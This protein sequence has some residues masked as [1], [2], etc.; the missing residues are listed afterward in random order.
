MK[1]YKKILSPILNIF[2]P[3]VCAICEKLDKNSLCNKCKLKLKNE[4]ICKIED[5]TNTSSYFDEHIY[6]CYYSG[7]IRD[8]ILDYK[9]NEKSYIYETFINILKNNEKIYVQLKKYDIIMPVPISKKRLKHRGYNQSAIF[10]R[11]VAD[12]FGIDYKENILVK[13]KDNKPQSTLGQEERLK[14]VQDVYNVI[15]E[16]KI[17]N[18]KI[19]IIDDIFTTGNTVNESAKVLIQNNVKNVGVL[20]IAKD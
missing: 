14:N 20:T 5:Y 6:L 7:Q 12:M 17:Y 1:F 10:A 2:Y 3:P 13:T 4:I 18:K 9:F 16:T 11:K 15:N 19:L 8:A